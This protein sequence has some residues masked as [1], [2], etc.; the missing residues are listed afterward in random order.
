[1]WLLIFYPRWDFQRVK[2]FLKI[3]S[4]SIFDWR[5]IALQYCFGFCHISTWVSH[6]CIYIYRLPLEPPSRLP[7]H[8]PHLGCYR[9]LD[10]GSPRHTAISTGGVSLHVVTY[11][12]QCDPLN[13]PH[14][15]LPCLCPQACFLCLH[16]HCCPA[17]RFISTIFPDSTYM[18]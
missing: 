3:L 16:L 13:S 2:Q 10:M 17:D 8:L 11:V 9:A 7:P 5:I 6:R 14:P 1:M 15:L 12:F 18:Y 4:L